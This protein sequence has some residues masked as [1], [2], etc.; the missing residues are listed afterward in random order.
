MSPVLAGQSGRLP[1][2][3]CILETE[4]MPAGAAEGW[5]VGRPRRREQREL[6]AEAGR[7]GE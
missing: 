4:R 7:P 3:G 5:A 2:D 1:A 6:T